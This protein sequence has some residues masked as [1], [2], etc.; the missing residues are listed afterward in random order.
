[1]EFQTNRI[2]VRPFTE[3]DRSRMIDLLTCPLFME[4]S[5]NGTLSIDEANKRFNELMSNTDG[6]GGKHA[7]VLKNGGK[8]IGY[9]GLEAFILNGSQEFELGYRLTAEFRNQGLATE[10]CEGFLYQIKSKLSNVY[11]LVEPLNSKS[12]NVLNKIGFRN[13]GVHIYMGHQCLLYKSEA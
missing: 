2:Q 11:A 7:L 9:C 3:V 1:M 8:L 12:I 6:Y 4:Y 13:I 10:A 5:A